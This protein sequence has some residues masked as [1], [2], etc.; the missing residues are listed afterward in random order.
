MAKRPARTAWKMPLAGLSYA[1]ACH[2]ADPQL[3]GTPVQ[4]DGKSYRVR[5]ASITLRAGEQAV[6]FTL[7]GD[8]GTTLRHVHH[9]RVSLAPATA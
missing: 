5:S 9:G 2:Y 6:Y 7:D 3:S 1:E 8:D 4:V